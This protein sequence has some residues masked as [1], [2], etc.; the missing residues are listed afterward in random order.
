MNLF[1]DKTEIEIKQEW[2]SLIMKD[3]VATKLRRELFAVFTPEIFRKYLFYY[4][5][6]WSKLLFRYLYDEVH[7]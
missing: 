7:S 3:F 5:D 1:I 4:D 2:I 6:G